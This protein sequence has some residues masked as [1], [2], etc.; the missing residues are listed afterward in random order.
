VLAADIEAGAMHILLIDGF[1][2]AAIVLNEHQ[3]AEYLEGCWRWIEGKILVIHRL[4]VS[5]RYQGKGNAKKMVRYAEEFA[6]RNG[7]STIRLDAF[8]QN[9]VSLRLYQGLGFQK[10]G[11]VTFRKGLFY[12][13]EKRIER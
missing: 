4:C 7:Y 2:A 10:A 1:P 11:N 9:P 6:K 5:P 12:L 3:D 8:S 13:F